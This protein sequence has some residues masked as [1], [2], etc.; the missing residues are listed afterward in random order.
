M[1][2]DEWSHTMSKQD[3]YFAKMNSQIVLPPMRR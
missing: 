3:D 2:L 1:M